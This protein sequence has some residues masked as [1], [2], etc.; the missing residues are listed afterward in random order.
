M[1]IDYDPVMSRPQ[2]VI[3]REWKFEGVTDWYQR[4]VV[5]N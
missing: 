5:E 3:L 4:Q 2:A 1:T